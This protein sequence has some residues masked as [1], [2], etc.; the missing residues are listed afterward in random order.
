VISDR[1]FYM[2]RGFL[3]AS[4]FL[5]V[6]LVVSAAVALVGGSGPGRHAASSRARVNTGGSVCG[7]PAGSQD[8]VVGPPAASWTLAGVMAVPG[9]RVFGPG[10]VEVNDRRCYQHSPVGALFSA[11]NLLAVTSPPFASDAAKAN[12]HFVHNRVWAI[13]S[14]QPPIPGDP[15]DRMQVAGFQT[16]VLDGDRVDVTLA[17]RTSING[18]QLATVRMMMRWAGGDWRV[19]LGSVDQPFTVAGVRSLEGFIPW[20]GA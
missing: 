11:A 10:V 19:L 14:R 9:S 18:G 5:V 15:Q 2:A 17:V 12:D 20:G 4:A 1:P 7:L 6:V 16:D 3:A 13:Y 8:P